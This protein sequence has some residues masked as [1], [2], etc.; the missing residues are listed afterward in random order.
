ME[1]QVARIAADQCPTLAALL[2]LAVVLFW[3]PF[4]QKHST[5]G[6]GQH[7]R[8]LQR[9]TGLAFRGGTCAHST[10]VADLSAVGPALCASCLLREISAQ[11][12]GSVEDPTLA[13][14]LQQDHPATAVRFPA[15]PAIALRAHE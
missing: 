10:E 15:T 2:T 6:G 13:F 3:M 7:S 11:H 12:H 1:H 9:G 14:E 4:I 5:R 8:V